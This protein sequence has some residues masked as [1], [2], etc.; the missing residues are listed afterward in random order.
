MEMNYNKLWKLLIGR[1]MTKT[2]M[3]LAAG[4]SIVTLARINKG[5]EFRSGTLRRIFEFLKRN[6]NDVADVSESQR[7]LARRGN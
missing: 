3:R 2:E 1:H 5:E 7:K 4:L 6:P